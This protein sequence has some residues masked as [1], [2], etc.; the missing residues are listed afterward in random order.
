MYMFLKKTTTNKLKEN[1]NPRGCLSCV[2]AIGNH[3][4]DR[5]VDYLLPFLTKVTAPVVNAN[6]NATLE[7]ELNQVLKKSVIKEVGDQKIGIIGYTTEE[8]PAL[9]SPGRK[10]LFVCLFMYILPERVCLLKGEHLL[11]HVLTTVSEMCFR[12]DERCEE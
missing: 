3:D 12:R 2:Q 6:I 11:C 4:F 10:S 1:R 7:P 5:G 9:S 8:T